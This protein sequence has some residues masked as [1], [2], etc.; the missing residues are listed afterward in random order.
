MS[1][2]ILSFATI[3]LLHVIIRWGQLVASS[4]GCDKGEVQLQCLQSLSVERLLRTQ[5]TAGPNGAQAVIDESHSSSPF[6]PMSPKEIMR[7]GEYNHEVSLL[8]GS[9]KDEGLLHTGAAYK[10]PAIVNEW[11]SKWLETFGPITLLGLKHESIDKH[12]REISRKIAEQYLY[13]IDSITFDNI[14]NI[15]NMY[16]DSWFGHPVHDFVSRRISNK[17]RTF[18][19]NS[20]FQYRFTHQGQLSLS[21]I[22]GQGGP[23][24]VNHADELFLMFSTL[25]GQAL[26]LNG[27]DKKMSD[28]LLSLWKSF[29]KTGKPSTEKITWDPI[30]GTS[31][32]Q[33]LNLN[34]KPFMEYPDEIKQNM[35]FWDKIVTEVDNQKKQKKNNSVRKFP[36][37]IILML[38]IMHLFSTQIIL[39]HSSSIV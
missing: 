13:S 17:R 26:V 21:I 30:L 27:Q 14:S 34:L 18:D 35:E 19:Q 32:R 15:T 7:S 9:N 4:V 24:G 33:Y 3:V 31:S 10:N 25:G 11:R 29:I 6:L 20:T 28:I 16:T 2:Y 23:Y 8:L 37:N 22:L 38:T 12:S 1:N 36:Q 5:L 39:F